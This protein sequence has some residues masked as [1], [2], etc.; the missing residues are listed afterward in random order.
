MSKSECRRKERREEKG[1]QEKKKRKNENAI[2]ELV[3]DGSPGGDGGQLKEGKQV[4][5]D[6]LRGGG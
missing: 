5:A 2:Q 6:Q 4:K 1:Q 3:G